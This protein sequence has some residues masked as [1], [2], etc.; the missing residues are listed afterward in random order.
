MNRYM[1]DDRYL[2]TLYCE[3]M[4]TDKERKSRYQE[5]N[6]TK[7]LEIEHINYSIIPEFIE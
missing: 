2:W 4:R 1:Y 6:S 7:G 5:E 3:N